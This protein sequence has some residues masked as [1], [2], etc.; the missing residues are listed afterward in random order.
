MIS[1]VL[2]PIALSF[3]IAVTTIPVIIKVAALKHLMDEPDTHRKLHHTKTP[4]LGGIGIFSGL[5]IGYSIAYDFNEYSDLRFIIPSLVILFLAGV[6]DDILVLDARKKLIL[7]VA[8]AL[9]VSAIGDLRLN[10]FWG[11]MGINEVS[12]IIGT[13]VSSL[14]IVTLINAFNFIDGV[15]G[16]AGSM[17]AV[18][19]LCFSVWFYINGSHGY[20]VLGFALVGALLGFLVFNFKNAKIFMGDTGSMIIGFI[21]AVLAIRFVEANRTIP[22]LAI[23]ILNAPAVALSIMAIPVYDLFKV[24]V[25]R[26]L[27]RKSPFNPDRMHIHH[28]FVDRGFSHTAT[29]ITLIITNLSCILIAIPLSDIRSAWA[30]IIVFLYLSILLGVAKYTC[31]RKH[32]F[33][34]NRY[35]TR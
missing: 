35:V 5:L 30:S 17:G 24:L 27:M 9:T 28:F 4:T 7:Q 13:L 23:P 29:T 34:K 1:N 32:L 14:I 10:N 12:P 2:L 11:I 33:Q 18:S 15:N 8:A 20:A 26:V 25:L 16:L 19:A 22:N 21:V 31:L 3:F 6:K